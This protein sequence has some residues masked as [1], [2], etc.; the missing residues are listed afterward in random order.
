MSNGHRAA[1][2]DLPL[3]QG[4]HG[5]VASQHVAEA[6]RHE[7]RLDVFEHPAGAVLIRVLLPQ[8]G[9]QLG[10]LPGLALLDLGVEALDDHLA[11]PLAGAHDVGG[12][13]RLVRGDENEPLAAMDHGGIGGFIGADGVVFDGLAGA[14][15][16]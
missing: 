11:Q 15:L 16:H 2:G 10:D 14:V 8:M 12:V 7:L 4:D 1:L 5:A 3:E 6:D 9:E 13:H